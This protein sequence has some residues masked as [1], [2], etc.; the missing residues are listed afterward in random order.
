MVG[1]PFQILCF[2]FLSKSEGWREFAQSAVG[3]THDSASAACGL[4]QRCMCGIH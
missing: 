4:L 3:L 1:H 2:L